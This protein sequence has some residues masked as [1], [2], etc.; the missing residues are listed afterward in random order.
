MDVFLW[1]QK[2]KRVGGLEHMFYCCEKIF[3]RVGGGLNVKM[4][5]EE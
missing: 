4:D 1:L 3:R 2:T 5:L